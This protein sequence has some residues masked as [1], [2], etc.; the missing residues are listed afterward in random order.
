VQNSTIM[1]Q[2]VGWVSG[3]CGR[4]GGFA[5]PQRHAPSRNAL[6]SHT[7]ATH[8]TAPHRTA[9]HRHPQLFA[10]VKF[11]DEITP[12]TNFRTFPDALLTLLRC[13]TGEGWNAI[14]HEAAN[15]RDCTRDPGYDAQVRGSSGSLGGSLERL[16]SGS[17][18]AL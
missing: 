8:R 7:H 17:R 14:M 11:G 12:H 4:V 6:T 15:Q 3:F 16:P 2:C 1:L 13:S 10:F 5:P 18:T 9:P